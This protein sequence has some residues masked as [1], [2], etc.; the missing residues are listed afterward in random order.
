MDNSITA[1]LAMKTSSPG[2]TLIE[3]LIVVAIVGILGATSMAIY[4]SARVRGGETV[5]VATLQAIT[6]AQVAFAQACGGQRYAPSLAALATPM[7]STGQPFISPDL[8][9]DPLIKGGY[10]FAM[11][12]TVVT[13]GGQTC[14]GV[15]PVGT[16]Q[17][18]AD[19]LRPGMS[20]VRFFAT[21]TDRV[22][23]EATETFTGK[24]PESGPPPHGVEMK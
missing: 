3:L 8:G 2:F 17:V 19:P 23:Y 6:Q 24:M 5:A 22:L 10:Q 14:T 4:R 20:G 9:T 7:P 21:N 1:I 18:T 16:Y 12:G 15:D 11:A 13:E